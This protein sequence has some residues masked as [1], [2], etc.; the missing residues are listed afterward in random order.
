MKENTCDNEAK[1]E[2]QHWMPTL[3]PSFFS[4]GS[5]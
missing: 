1:A 3:G 4:A 2:M 5:E